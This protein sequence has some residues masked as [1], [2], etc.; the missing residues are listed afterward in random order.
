MEFN[1][2]VEYWI[3]KDS[4]NASCRG[5][6]AIDG[7]ACFN[8]SIDDIRALIENR[9]LVKKEKGR[10]DVSVA[11]N[12]AYTIFNKCFDVNNCDFCYDF[13]L[14]NNCE[15]NNRVTI[16]R[17]KFN[18]IFD[19]SNSHFNNDNIIPVSISYN[20]FLLKAK[21]DGISSNREIIVEK[22]IFS[23]EV[24]FSNSVFHKRVSI[25]NCTFK[26]GVKFNRVNF[27][28]DFSFI[29]NEVYGC[30]SFENSIFEGKIELIDIKGEIGGI[31]LNES[32]IKSFLELNGLTSSLILPEKSSIKLKNVFVEPNGYLMIR[33]VNENQKFT[34]EVDFTN[35]N[36]LGNVVLKNIYLKRFFLTNAV[37]VG[38]FYT[39][40]LHFKEA[41]DSQT[42]VRLKNEALKNNNSIKAMQYREKEMSSYSKELNSQRS[43]SNFFAW[44]T[45]ESILFLNTVSNK[46]GLSWLRGIFFT[47]VCAIVFFWIINFFGIEDGQSRFFILDFKTFHFEGVGEIWKRFLN[48]FYLIDFKEK[49]QGIE[50]N[51]IGE[52]VFFVSKIFISYGIYQIVVAF[53]KFSK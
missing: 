14:Y 48:M 5:H 8:Y 46:N 11:I 53:R 26:K 17:N 7:D 15:F 51:A 32:V 31:N 10:F 39:E 20:D 37:M 19:I 16:E 21:F 2:K 9:Y 3:W 18:K 35:A 27:I 47:L 28:N 4:E 23:D 40:H 42:Y 50:L 13:E 52:T 12:F 29:N 6:H 44:L 45:D 38:G 22:C 41:S 1:S 36:L 49:F 33:N 30:I 25:K 43:L 34:G 24:D